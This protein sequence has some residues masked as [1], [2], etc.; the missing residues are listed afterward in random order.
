MVKVTIDKEE[1]VGCGVCY[2]DECPD[3]FEEGA[4]GTSN[5]RAEF[6]GEGPFSGD[7]PDDLKSG[8]EDAADA[9]PVDAIVVE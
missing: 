6:R 4:D 8:V 7:V 5:L 9:C 3:V 2:E 1:C